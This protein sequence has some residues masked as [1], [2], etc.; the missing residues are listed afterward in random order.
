MWLLPRKSK[1][2]NP[3]RERAACLTGI[4]LPQ[5]FGRWLQDMKN[6]TK[7]VSKE[8]K[9]EIQY[10]E[11]KTLRR[12]IQDYLIITLASGIYAVSVSLFLDP[13]SLAPGGVTGIAIILNRITGLETGTWMFLINIP[14]LALG[15]WKFGWK[16]ILST[17]YCTLATSFVTNLL[18]PVGALTTDPLLAALVGASLMA[19]SLGLVFKAGAT[20]GGTDIIIKLLRLRFPHLKTGFLFL[21]TDA[22]IVTASAFVFQNLDTALYAGLVVFI[23]SVMLDLVLYGRD[24]A[25]MFF[26]ISDSS[27]AIVARLLEELDISA[28]Y[29]SGSGAYTGADKK[30]ILCVVK[31]PL[32]P[33]LEEIVRQEDPKAFTI[34]TSASEIYGEGYKNIFS[35]KL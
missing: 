3:R 26:I 5:D 29:I 22:V 31:K 28:T 1:E 33:K 23:N 12:R 4:P 16:F 27:Q 34:I 21:L 10:E 9:S 6:G 13:N 30:V 8:Q 32:S 20:T 35:Q 7:Q 2:M 11:K 14:I 18:T 25:K 15:M 19:V 24:G 17:L